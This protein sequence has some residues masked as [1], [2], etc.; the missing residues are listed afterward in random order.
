MTGSLEPN[1][2]GEPR[3]VT[4]AFSDGERIGPVMHAALSVDGRTV[5]LATVHDHGADTESAVAGL[6]IEGDSSC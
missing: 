4:G 1:M 2:R 5:G 6:A 3:D